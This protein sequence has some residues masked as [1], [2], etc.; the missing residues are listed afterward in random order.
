MERP[1][2]LIVDDDPDLRRA[3]KIRLQAKHYDTVHASD[4][5]SAISM[6]QKERHDLIILDLGLPGGD[7]FGVLKRLQD[8]DTLSNIPVIVLTARSPQ[9]NEQKALLAGAAAFFQ[10][11]VDNRELLDVIR[12]NVPNTWPSATFQS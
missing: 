5:Y 11:P 6:A 12:A 10:K 4:S 1:K 8:A 9:F 2:I 3:M 7:G